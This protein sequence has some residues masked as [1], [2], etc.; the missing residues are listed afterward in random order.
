[1]KRALVTG[2]AGFIGST[3]TRHL[4]Q[5]GYDVTVF[6][7][8]SFGRKEH[9]WPGVRLVKGDI[10]SQANVKRVLRQP[11]DVVFHLAAIHFIPFCNEHPKETIEINIEGTRNFLEILSQRPPKKLFFAS[12]AA[13]YNIG[14][15]KHTLKELPEPMDIY[16]LTKLSGEH[17]VRHFQLKTSTSCSIGRLFNAY[18]PNETNPHLIPHIINQLRAGTRTLSLGNLKP[19]R[20]YIHTDDMC[21]GILGLT[22]KQRRGLGMAN[23]ASGEEYSVR[24]VVDVFSSVLGE[25][26]KIKSKK[27]LRRKQE[28]DHLRGD[29]KE[30]KRLAKWKKQVPFRLGIKHL[31]V[32]EGLTQP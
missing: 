19:F 6:D 25:T 18:G 8:L 30:L 9:I 14:S 23:I 13:V 12:T 27:T 22:L 21:R 17:L 3:L 29:L 26:L 15:H 28:R 2:G 31:L 5:L 1:M 7:N 24:E 20:D 4:L 16:G 11:F 32:E 10:R